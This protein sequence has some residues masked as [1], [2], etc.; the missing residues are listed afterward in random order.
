MHSDNG[1]QGQGVA[2]AN[3]L[4]LRDT[5]GRLLPGSTA[6]RNGRPK[7]SINSTTKLA[8][9]RAQAGA[10]R[11]VKRLEEM[12]LSNDP[13]LALQAIRVLDE[14]GRK[15]PEDSTIPGPEYFTEAE[16][17]KIL[18]LFARAR[19]RRDEGRVVRSFE[20]LTGAEPAPHPQ[21]EFSGIPPAV[22]EVQAI[23]IPLKPR[24]DA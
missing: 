10:A 2:T 13:Y 17:Q 4:A 11:R 7:G 20:Q 9:R 23:V 14:I 8:A 16:E 15:A 1:Q 21:Q 18:K 19:R 24:E 22:V 3:K 5:R 12:A 6:N